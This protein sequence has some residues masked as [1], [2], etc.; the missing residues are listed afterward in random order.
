MNAILKISL[1]LAATVIVG[2]ATAQ[3]TFYEHDGFRGRSFTTDARVGDFARYGFN[4]RAS[5]V[6]VARERWEVCDDVGFRGR[7]IILRPGSYASLGEIGL[8]DRISSARA[9]GAQERAVAPGRVVPQVIF[10]EHDDFVGRSL[11]T[12]RAIEDFSRHNFN[13]V[14]SSVIV[15]GSP[16]EV[17]E[18]A[19]FRG[20]CILL[21]P[22]RYASLGAMGLNDRISSVRMVNPPQRAV[23]VPEAAATVPVPDYASA[24]RRAP[25]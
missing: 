9:V 24:R 16:W 13:D 20:R 25:V 10:Y 22:G 12:D 18:D 23:G 11:P 17:C 15:V 7:C 5:S 4:D 14:A 21:Q 1:T 2:Q 19:E 3:I 6:V 8:N